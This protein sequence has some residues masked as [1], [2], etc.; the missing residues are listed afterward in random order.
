M[1]AWTFRGRELRE[2]CEGPALLA[3]SCVVGVLQR[4]G[5]QKAADLGVLKVLVLRRSG[6][7]TVGVIL[8]T[9]TAFVSDG[10]G[11]AIFSAPKTL[12]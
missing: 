4:P 5:V 2:N 1:A 10:V 9:H 11:V 12:T 8:S 7:V 6:A 3:A